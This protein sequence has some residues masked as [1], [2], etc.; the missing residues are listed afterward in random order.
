MT[1]QLA[2]ARGRI[3]VA[4]YLCVLA[5]GILWGIQWPV[6]RLCQAEGVPPLE[7]AFWRALIGGACFFLHALA[8][9]NVAARRRDMLLFCL[10]GVYAVGMQFAIIQI[11]IR[12]SGAALSAVLLYS[13]PAWVAMLSRFLFK[14]PLSRVKLLALGI[15]MAGVAMICLSGGSMAGKSPSILGI[16]LGLLSAVVYATIFIFFVAWKERYSTATIYAYMLLAGAAALFPFIEVSLGKS[17]MAWGG[18]A[19]MGVLTC[20]GAFYTYGQSLR[21]LSPVKVAVLCNLEPVVGAFLSW[22]WWNETFPP[23]GWAGSV[24]VIAAIVLLTV[25]G[26]E[27]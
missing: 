5:A 17:G 10:F 8:T 14:E 20:Y 11:A 21:S 26:Q 4:G 15:A 18:L 2:A 9:R 7:V 25:A 24:L 19:I 13:A 6:S 3:P 1:A 12:E 22:L 16:G 27:Q 23:I